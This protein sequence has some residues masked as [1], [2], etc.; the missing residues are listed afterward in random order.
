MT[1]NLT[2]CFT[3]HRDIS[4]EHIK[5][6]PILLDEILYEQIDNGAKNFITGGAVG[7][8]T[9]AALKVL[10]MKDRFGFINLHLCLPCKNQTQN[11][12]LRDIKAY[13]YILS[14]ADSKEYISDIYTKFCMHERNR[15]MVDKSNICIAYCTENRGG[16]AY[17]CSYALKNGLE[18][19][20][21][22]DFLK[23]Y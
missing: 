5:D 12:N 11:W 20:N 14:R 17:T 3:G 9:L 22:F 19:I 7:F 1:D 15:K 6:L 23:K 13:E 21:L 2:C 16:T 18:L 10:E 4:R 8:D